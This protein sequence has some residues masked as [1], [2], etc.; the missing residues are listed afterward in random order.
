MGMSDVIWASTEIMVR[1]ACWQSSDT[2]VDHT[3]APLPSAQC[4][5]LGVGGLA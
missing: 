5:F 1:S 4:C 3:E 2:D